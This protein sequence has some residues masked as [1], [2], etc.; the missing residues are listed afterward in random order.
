MKSFSNFLSE[1]ARRSQAVIQAQR[2]GLKSDGHGGWYDKNGEFT[3][4]TQAG[5][6]VFF[7]KG[8]EEGQDPPQSEKDKRLSGEGPTEAQR[9]AEAAA[10]A[11]IEAA[12]TAS[13]EAENM[14]Q[15]KAPAPE[16]QNPVQTKPA[17]VPKTKGTLTIAYGRFN[18]PTVGHEKL[19]DKVA[20]SSDDN[21]YI[22][23]P[24]RSEDKK[25]NPI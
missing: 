20:A 11:D 3:A 7:N 5:K 13:G 18:P 12:E 9:D 23:V 21:D 10:A 4:K 1:A 2:L 19:M 8:Q 24:S 22:I 6:L 15:G 14:P 16:S 25:K 17:D